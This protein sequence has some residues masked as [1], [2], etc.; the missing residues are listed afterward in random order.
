MPAQGFTTWEAAVLW[1][2]SQPDQEELVRAAYYDD[3]VIEAAQRY[4]CSAEWLA[5]RELLTGRTGKAL[6]VGAGRG[7][8]SYA[9]AKEGFAVTAVEPDSSAIVG[10][11]AIRSLAAS[12]KLSIE[13]V[14]EYSESLSFADATFDVVF[15]RAVLHHAR[16]LRAVARELYRVLRPGGLLVATREHVISRPQDLAAFQ[17]QHALH[18]LYGGE[19]AYPLQEYSGALRRAGFRLERILGPMDSA[20]NFAPHTEDGLRREIARRLVASRAAGRAVQSLLGV[21]VVWRLVRW[22]FAM[23]DRR[24]GRHYSF[25]CTRP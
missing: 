18:R 16:D 2:R 9:L 1:L 10:A 25:V 13:V 3:P 11:G 20:I 14:Q 19:A 23:F 4:W 5:T 7:I 17:A 12:A 24:P 6:D 22:L 15:A 21:T 8:A